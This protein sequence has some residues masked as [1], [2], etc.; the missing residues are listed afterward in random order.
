MRKSPLATLV[1]AALLAASSLFAPTAVSAR[2]SESE[3]VHY[4]S[5]ETYTMLVGTEFWSCSGATYLTGVRS[6]YAVSISRRSCGGGGDP[7]YNDWP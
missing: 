4:F 7:P 6:E 1:A 2:P 3:L 5:D